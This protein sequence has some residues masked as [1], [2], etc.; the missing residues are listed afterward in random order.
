VDNREV[1]K[2]F[3]LLADLLEFK[4]EN[5]FKVRSYRKVARIIDDLTD[6]VA[7]ISAAGQL[8]ELP[9]VGEATAKKIKE[10]IET[11]RITRLEEAKAGV[12][13]G[14][15]D[16]L[17]IQGVGPK[18]AAMLYERIGIDSVAALE[19][20]AEG[21]RV[22]GLPGMGAKSEENIL[23][24]IRL[25]QAGA[26]R[27]LLDAALAA[28]ETVIDHLTRK[29][30]LVSRITPAGSLRRRR[31]SIGDV[32]VLACGKD[33]AKILDAFVNGPY[34][35][36]VLA[37][38]ETKASVILSEGVQVDLR[39][40]EPRQ[41]GAALQYF[42]GSKAHNIKLR[43][44]AK[45]KKMKINE[46]GLFKG[47]KVVASKKEDDIYRALGMEPMAPEMREDRGEIEAAVAGELPRLVGLGD[48]KGDFHV[49]SSYSDGRHT[50][51]EIAKAAKAAG[52]KFVAITD[53]SQSLRIANGLTEERVREQMKEIA[54]LN[55]KLRGIKVLCG[56]EVDIKSGGSLDLP[57][58]LLA[59]LD[60]VIA[61]IHSGFRQPR[62][63]IM[64]R[65]AA[66]MKSPHVDIIGHPTG[67]L[68]GKREA[69]DV[70]VPELIRAAA[71]TGTA[72]EINAHPQ[73]L[74]LNDTH[75]RTAKEHGVKLAIGTDAH[76]ADDLDMM[77]FGVSVARRGWLEPK[78]VLNTKTKP[79]GPS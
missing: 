46:Y 63:K 33:A 60:V 48:I 29:R 55:K 79:V 1:A 73:R 40:V 10:Y 64:G 67:R 78:D 65:I 39:V 43:H 49:H 11:G 59:E 20:A 56:T 5:A 76:N 32:D 9:G 25:R 13:D 26:G 74:D 38:G 28:A 62:E 52:Y 34:A 70:D 53:H 36:D 51:G 45:Q 23:R 69:Y 68:I 58:K 31:D 71:A 30:G 15:L 47:R 8:R 7:D 44:I 66:A 61:S 75:C 12:P 54:A 3:E 72:L 14:I 24:G 27:M 50:I 2:Q 22:R 57:D 42:T 17:E 16:V 6:D 41:F 37:A 18:R 4:G 21:Q 77:R 35:A 19:K